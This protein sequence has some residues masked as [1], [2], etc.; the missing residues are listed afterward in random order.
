M[1]AINRLNTFSAPKFHKAAPEAQDVA[2]T[3]AAGVQLSAMAFKLL[4]D[5]A[6]SRSKGPL[7]GPSLFQDQGGGGVSSRKRGVA[8]LRPLSPPIP[9]ASTAGDW[10]VTR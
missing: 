2:G 7:P 8:L 4:S 6:P 3:N 9:R 1:V 10:E 5:E